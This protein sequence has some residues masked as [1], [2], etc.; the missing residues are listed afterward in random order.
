M[1]GILILKL[2]TFA[3]NFMEFVNIYVQF[4]IMLFPAKFHH[5][6]R[7]VLATVRKTCSKRPQINGFNLFMPEAGNTA[8]LL[9]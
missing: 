4:L 3:F 7:P 6:V 5:F 8:S 9:R 2:P 1:K